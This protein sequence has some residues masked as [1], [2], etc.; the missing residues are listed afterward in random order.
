MIQRVNRLDH[1]QANPLENLLDAD[2]GD[3]LA[4]HRLAST[5]MR[6]VAGHRGRGVV[7]H[8]QSHSCLVVNGIHH[9]SYR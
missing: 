1:G 2:L 5:R 3:H 7:Q 4:H 6:L 9:A 8:D